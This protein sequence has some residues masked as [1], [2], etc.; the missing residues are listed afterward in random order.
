METNDIRSL[1]KNKGVLAVL[2]IE[3]IEDAAPVC[4]ALIDGG[5]S[6][7]ELALRT[8]A[9]EPSIKIIKE[10]VPQMI[11]GAGTLIQ[12]GQAR[13]IKYLGADFALS[14]GYNPAIALEAKEAQLPFVPGI[15]TPSELEAAVFAGIRV[16]KFFPSQALGGVSY[17]KSM[18]YPYDYLKLQYIP[19]GGINSE[20]L[21]YY[22]D[23][24]QVLAV[25]GTWIAPKL[26]I[27]NKAWDEIT[28]LARRAIK[29][30]EEYR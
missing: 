25:G 18:N 5:I 28:F 27:K 10:K 3:N 14:P 2:E 24:P 26:L 8:A 7:I 15:A 30:W 13:R 6:G 1:L 17:L 23:M 29:T 11:I 4:E 20:N 16:L 9:A 21:G 19:L 12:K 22:A